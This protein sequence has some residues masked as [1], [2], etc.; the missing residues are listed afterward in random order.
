VYYIGNGL[1]AG[2]SFKEFIAPAGATRLFLGI[3]DG[4]GFNGP[5]GAYDDNDGAYRIAIGINQVPVPE[6]QTY[7][8]LGLGLGVL[9]GV[10]RRK[11]QRGQT[12]RA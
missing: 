9:A 5:P 11:A 3:P 6:P 7:A 12:C 1:T 10:A 4:F 8:M 2:G